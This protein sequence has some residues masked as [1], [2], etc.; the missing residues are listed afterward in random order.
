[1]RNFFKD[2]VSLIPPVYENNS[3]YTPYILEITKCHT[4]IE[5]YFQNMVIKFSYI[6]LKFYF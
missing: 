5:T 4:D 6:Y 1:M 2:M 3:P